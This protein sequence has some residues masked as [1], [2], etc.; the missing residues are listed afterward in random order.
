MVTAKVKILDDK[1]FNQLTKQITRGA[2]DE[3]Q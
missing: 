1:L 3:T 2:D